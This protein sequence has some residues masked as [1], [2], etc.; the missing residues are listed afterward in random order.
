MHSSRFLR[1]FCMKMRDWITFFA[2]LVLIATAFVLGMRCAAGKSQPVKIITDTLKV[3]QVLTDT[4][5][6]WYERVV[7]KE[8]EPETVVVYADTIDP[9]T[10]WGRWPEA[11]VS[12]DYSR[13]RTG[14]GSLSFTSLAPVPDS[15]E[16]WRA[17]SPACRAAL[18]G[19]SYR[20]G[21]RFAVRA[22]GDGFF[23]KTLREVPHFEAGIGVEARLWADTLSS[24][25]VPYAEASVTWRGLG[26]GPK[27]D[28]RG[29][30]IRLG[31]TWHF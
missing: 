4:V 28:T 3:T 21:E 24:R 31:Y 19:Y 25:I 7:W 9:D 30:H 20:V 23:V 13:S 14:K 5:L 22:R 17:G 12:L 8:A 1:Q 11:I 2:S 15:E 27:L 16:A 18:K 29:L 26:F 6:R 10:V